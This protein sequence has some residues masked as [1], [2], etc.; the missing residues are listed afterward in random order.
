MRDIA[1]TVGVTERAT[2]RIT[3]DLVEAGYLTRERIGRR[4]G[5]RINPDARM[6]HP[7]Q[8]DHAVGEL[9]TLLS[10]EEEPTP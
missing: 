5:Y 9:L 6:C 2:Q 1:D 8:H 4:N 7:A 10:S 3:N